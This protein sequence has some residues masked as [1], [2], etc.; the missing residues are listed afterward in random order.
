MKNRIMVIGLIALMA[1]GAIAL[2]VHRAPAKYSLQSAIATSIGGN[3]KLAPQP[4]TY[5][6]VCLPKNWQSDPVSK[7]LMLDT[8]KPNFTRLRQVA[9]TKIYVQGDADFEHRFHGPV[10]TLPA[11]LVQ[12][13][14]GATA[15]WSGANCKLA[16]SQ[17]DGCLRKL[18]HRPK[19]EPEKPETPEPAKPSGPELPD[20]PTVNNPPSEEINKPAVGVILGLVGLAVW[21]IMFRNRPS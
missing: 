8:G 9:A 1:V 16:E 10:Q 7:Q 5:L 21:G 12:T 14:D 15:K 17:V 11:V 3:A 20:S 2:T 13:P 19:P 18:L 4:D 6:T